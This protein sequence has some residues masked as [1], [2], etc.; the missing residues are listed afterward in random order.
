MEK[1]NLLTSCLLFGAL[2]GMAEA[3]LGYL[4]HLLPDGIPGFVMFPIGFFFM[5]RAFLRTGKVQSI[6]LVGLVAAAIKVTQLMLPFLPAI[7]VLV[8]AAAI[9]FEA[10][11]VAVSY[12]VLKSMKRKVTIPGILVSSIG[13]RLAYMAL[14]YALTLFGIPSGYISAG[15]ESIASFILLE[16]LVNAA[17]IF[18]V[19]RFKW[20][21]SAENAKTPHP[22]WSYGAFVLSVAA[23]LVFAML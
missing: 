19:F 4:L 15:W 20:A 22:V 2:W 6:F 14:Q 17:I 13:W 11:L 5:T 10:S 1:K 7:K 16:G 18:I 23:T 9:I 12:I 21:N 3:T 8:P